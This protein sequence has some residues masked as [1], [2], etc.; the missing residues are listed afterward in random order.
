MVFRVSPDLFLFL[1]FLSFAQDPVSHDSCFHI[2]FSVFSAFLLLLLLFWSLGSCHC[3]VPFFLIPLLPSPSFWYLTGEDRA[4]AI[5]PTSNFRLQE[6]P[7]PKNLT[8]FIW[9]FRLW[10]RCTGTLGAGDSVSNAPVAQSLRREVVS[11]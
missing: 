1:F 7:I 5:R 9:G 11:R 8:V 6:G 4:G 10:T 3:C 2:C